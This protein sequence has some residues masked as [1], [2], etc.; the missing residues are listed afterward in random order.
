M[1]DT[2]K[3]VDTGLLEYDDYDPDEQ[4]P[5]RKSNPGKD[6]DEYKYRHDSDSGGDIREVMDVGFPKDDNNGPDKH[7]PG[8]NVPDNH[9]YSHSS[10]SEEWRKTEI[11]NDRAVIDEIFDTHKTVVAFASAADLNDPFGRVVYFTETLGGTQYCFEVKIGISIQ[12]YAEFSRCDTPGVVTESN[13]S[14]KLGTYNST[15]STSSR[16]VYSDGTHCAAKVLRS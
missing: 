13:E 7:E 4:E 5:V 11:S 12:Q 15:E 1:E 3:A 10:G 8:G 16:Q 6:M 14:Y 9:E 2:R